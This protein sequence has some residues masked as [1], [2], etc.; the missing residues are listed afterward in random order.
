MWEIFGQSVDNCYMS[1]CIF[2]GGGFAFLLVMIPVSLKLRTL[3]IIYTDYWTLPWMPHCYRALPWRKKNK[4]LLGILPSVGVLLH[5]V[6]DH[7]E[8]FPRPRHPGQR[9]CSVQSSTTRRPVPHIEDTLKT[10]KTFFNY[11]P[12]VVYVT[13]YFWFLVSR[14]GDENKHHVPNICRCMS[15]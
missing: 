14:T 5:Q 15:T 1:Q 13:C 11:K 6:T 9:T 8:K 2:S 7:R 3:T 10:L 4:W 12:H